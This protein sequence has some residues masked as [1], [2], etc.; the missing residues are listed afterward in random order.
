MYRLVC[1]LLF[2]PLACTKPETEPAPAAEIAPAPVNQPTGEVVSFSGE[3]IP[4]P[5]FSDEARA[6][7]EAQLSEARTNYEA[8]PSADN[9]IWLGRRTAYLGRYQE[10]IKI[11][12]NLITKHPEDARLY[13]HRGHRYISIRKLDEAIADY[14]RAVELIA[15]KEDE[16]EPDGMPNA[17]NLPRTTLQ[18]NIWYHLGLARY[19]KG[20]FEGALTAYRECLNVSKNDDGLTS[21]SHWLYMTLRRLNRA[22]EAAK[23][24][25]QIQ[26]EMDIIENH[27]YHRLLLMYKG[28]LQP[29]ALFNPNGEDALNAATEG[30]GVANWYF[31]N[32]EKEKAQQALS[33]IL[34]GSSKFAF[35][36]IAAESDLARVK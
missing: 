31:Y 26:S 17:Q 23:V 4:A 28:E 2:L 33:A 29:E 35:G 32:G 22:E 6:K 21:T 13:R 16:V 7:M 11:Y 8:D 30:Y 15:G 25:E 5:T 18:S 36:Y 3:P 24:L 9:G 1:I 20:D 27:G 14:E 34:T 12:S 10:A 19:L